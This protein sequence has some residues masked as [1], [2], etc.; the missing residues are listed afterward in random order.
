MHEQKMSSQ[1]ILKPGCGSYLSILVAAVAII[2]FFISL[3]RPP[4]PAQAARATATADTATRTVLAAMP[5]AT[6]DVPQDY[7][8]EIIPKLDQ[9][10]QAVEQLGI[11]KASDVTEEKLNDSEWIT[12][13]ANGASALAGAED[14]LHRMT[15][16]DAAQLLHSQILEIAWSCVV[17]AHSLEWHIEVRRAEDLRR[18][19]LNLNL[20]IEPLRQIQTWIHG[21]LLMPSPTPQISTQTLL[22]VPTTTPPLPP[23]VANQPANLRAGPGTTYAI[24]GSAAQ[25]QTLTI[26]ARNAAGDWYQLDSGAWI[27]SFL[28]DGALDGL[29]VADD[30]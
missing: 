11:T 13:I 2:L 29:P 22:L 3:S 12:V 7:K 20:C 25:G 24:V 18:M 21:N 15:P 28:V 8:T 14:A 16:P 19:E 26:I 10:M 5:T 9:L 6:P 30:P 27:A 23:A 1:L 17:A 4:N